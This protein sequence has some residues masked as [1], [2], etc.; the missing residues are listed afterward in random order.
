[1]AKFCNVDYYSLNKHFQPEYASCVYVASLICYSKNSTAIDI[2]Q[3]NLQSLECYFKTGFDWHCYK[4]AILNLWPA[5]H[6][7]LG[8]VLYAAKDAIINPYF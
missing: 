6:M 2:L 1:M 8:D 4:A 5:G 3:A 7:W